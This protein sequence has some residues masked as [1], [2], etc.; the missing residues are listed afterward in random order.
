MCLIT[1]D[2]TKYVADKDI[3]TYKILTSNLTSPYYGFPPFQYVIGVKNETEIRESHLWSPFSELDGK[4]LHKNYPSYYRHN[5]LKCFGQGFHSFNA[6]FL[7]NDICFGNQIV[8]KCIIPKGSEYYKN[9]LGMF[10]SNKIIIK[11][12]LK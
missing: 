9:P 11:K 4:W 7:T 10:V 12:I 3:V 1:N 6:K 2:L 8:V 5:D